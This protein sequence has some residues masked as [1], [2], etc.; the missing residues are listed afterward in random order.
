MSHGGDD[1]GLPE[2][3]EEHVNHEAWVIPYA[4]L[5]TLLM[6]MF[7]ALFA[8]STVDMS[9][10]KA[11]SVGFNEAL[12]G[13]KLNSGIGGD[14]KDSSPVFGKG[15]GKGPFSGGTLAPTN[16]VPD[17]T[18]LASLLAATQNIAAAKAAQAKQL[19][20]VAKEI[21]DAA[22]AGGLVGSLHLQAENR[23]LVI[24]LVT[25]RVLFDSGS[26]QLRDE[27]KALLAIVGDSLR[28]ID[29][30]ILI[31]GYTDD[32]PINTGQFPSNL[33]LSLFRAGSVYDFFVKTVGLDAE[34]LHPEGL[35]D[36][37]PVASNG[38]PDGRAKNRRVEIIVQS[39]LV[40]QVQ[41]QNGINDNPVDPSA[42]ANPITPP[43]Q[44]GVGGAQPNL[45]PG[46]GAK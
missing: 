31:D 11:F 44:S 45:A 4:D 12:G 17:A 20:D 39:K 41:D 26:A 46:L 9:K 36:K 15:N 25:D 28:G 6:A 32:T 2:E 23:G 34:R 33:Y 38:T 42:P 13:G 37:D 40:K 8:M 22:K 14:A 29:N 18:K 35:G 21:E 5:L 19:A 24:T 7:I 10:F 16:N 3:H 30:T 27:G 43:A 1:G